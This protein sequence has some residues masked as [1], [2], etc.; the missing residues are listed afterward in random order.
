MS[1]KEQTESDLMVEESIDVEKPQKYNVLLINDNFTPM[2][3][4]VAILVNV[5]KKNYEEA[6]MITM[7]IHENGKGIAGTYTKEIAEEKRSVTL[8][9]AKKYEHPLRCEIEAAAPE[10]TPK[11]K[12]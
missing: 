10:S 12:M 4:V 1:I 8:A 2:D 3:F 6:E 11:F 5:F 9:T 7:H